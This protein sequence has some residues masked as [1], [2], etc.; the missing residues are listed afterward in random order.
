MQSGTHNEKKTMA[1]YTESIITKENKCFICGFRGHLHIHHVFGG[2]SNRK[3]S[4]KYGLKVPLCW[5]DH[6]GTNGVHNNRELDL[7]LKRIAQEKF[8]ETHSREEFI[9]IFGKVGYKASKPYNHSR[10]LKCCCYIPL[11]VGITP[12]AFNLI[13]YKKHNMTISYI[14]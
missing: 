3:N 5:E 2:T 1:K 8:E 7:Y 6:E 4:E 12:N 13:L 10:G 11:K 14:L 9:S